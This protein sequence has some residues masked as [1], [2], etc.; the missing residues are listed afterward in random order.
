MSTRSLRHSGKSDDTRSQQTSVASGS[1]KPLRRRDHESGTSDRP[2]KDGNS[3]LDGHQYSKEKKTSHK[4]IGGDNTAGQFTQSRPLQHEH[5]RHRGSH[6]NQDATH[7]TERNIATHPG[8]HSSTSPKGHSRREDVSSLYRDDHFN[9]CDQKENEY[10][11]SRENNKQP[12]KVIIRRRRAKV[13]GEKQELIVEV[14]DKIKRFLGVHTRKEDR[15]HFYLE[16]VTACK[17]ISDGRDSC[18]EDDDEVSLH[19]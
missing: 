6:A 15:K 18:A 17:A 2:G 19:S 5:R 8:H 7:I 11:R 16:K 13:A 3:Q 9:N 1:A 14:V 10:I 4:A 12:T